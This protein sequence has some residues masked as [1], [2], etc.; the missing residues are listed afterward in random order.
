MFICDQV[1]EASRNIKLAQVVHSLALAS[2]KSKQIY[3]KRYPV[4]TYFGSFLLRS[5]PESGYLRD[6]CPNGIDIVLIIQ[7]PESTFQPSVFCTG[8]GFG[9]L[10]MNGPS[11]LV[12]LCSIHSMQF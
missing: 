5:Y 8:S 3:A 1:L 6:K 2:F 12:R 10:G 9:G 7:I 4:R 11:L